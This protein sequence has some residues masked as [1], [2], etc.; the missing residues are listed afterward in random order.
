MITIVLPI[1][2]T[3]YLRP[4][5]NCLDKLERPED[6][7]LLIITDGDESLAR[8]VDRRLDS[9]SYKRIQVIS[10]GDTPAE[11]IDSR[12]YRIAAIHNKA[13]HFVSNECE[14]VFLVEDDTAYPANSLAKMLRTMMSPLMG[15]LQNGFIQGTELGRRKTPYVGGWICDDINNP[16]VISSVMPPRGGQLFSAIDAGGLYCC[17]VGFDLYKRHMFEPFDKEGNNGLSCDLNFGLWMSRQG[18]DCY[19]DWSI[20]CDHIGEKG[21]VNLGNTKPVQVVFERVNGKWL[22]SVR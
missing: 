3:D 20:V 2:R 17:L 16:A 6:T 5:F 1:S 9:I 13:K 10:F 22:S 4:V 19:I 7:E 12:R 15:D 18:Y 11:D 8:A 21:S 14:Y